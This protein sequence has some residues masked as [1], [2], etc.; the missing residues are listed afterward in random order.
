MGSIFRLM[1]SMSPKVPKYSLMSVSF[2][3]WRRKK[4]Q[5]Q[6]FFSEE[7]PVRRLRICYYAL[8]TTKHGHFSR[9]EKAMISMAPLRGCNFTVKKYNFVQGALDIDLHVFTST[10]L[11]KGTNEE[12]PVIFMD[13][14]ASFSHVSA[15][16]LLFCCKNKGQ[17][18][19]N[20][21]VVLSSNLQEV[22]IMYEMEE[23]I[24]FWGSLYAG[25]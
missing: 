10:Y 23:A 8:S 4:S 2:A 25:I 17:K 12:F 14:I 6:H 22:R 15:F 3:S 21:Q 5:K 19:V 18:K 13:N 24:L 16:S 1:F 9:L 11:G 20:L 7:N